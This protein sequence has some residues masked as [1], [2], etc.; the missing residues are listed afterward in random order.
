MNSEEIDENAV[1]RPL[2]DSSFLVKI[3]GGSFCWSDVVQDSLVLKKSVEN[4]L[5]PTYDG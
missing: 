1:D 4:S 5:L 2:I 3:E